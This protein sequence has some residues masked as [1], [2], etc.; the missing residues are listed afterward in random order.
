[1]DFRD[2]NKACPKDD[3]PLPNLDMLVDT[4]ANHEMFSFMDDFSGYNQIKMY[5]KD[6]KMIA[7]RTQFGNFYYRVMTFG[8]KNVETT[9][10][11]AMT[12]IFHDMIHNY[13]EGYVDDLVVKSKERKDHLD[14]LN[15]V[16]ER[17]REYELKMNPLKCTFG[18]TKGKFLGFSID[19]DGIKLDQDK[20]KAILGMKLPQNLKQ[21]R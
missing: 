17:C 8:L 15:K 13:V 7:F 3:F 16:F 1:M 11:R 4:T 14:H 9:Y 6:A 2:L 19:K 10:Q 21:I 18:V 12:V 5:P 20:A